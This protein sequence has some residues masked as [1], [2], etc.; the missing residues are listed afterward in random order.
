MLTGIK[1][2][3]SDR[4]F[5]TNTIIGSTT[6]I[7]PKN[8]IAAIFSRVAGLS[9]DNNGQR[10][11]PCNSTDLVP[12]TFTMGSHDFILNPQEYLF[13]FSVAGG[14]SIIIFH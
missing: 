6:M 2:D 5:D 14:V 1:S 7:L 9:F 13:P 3:R 11:I 4:L 8:V 10:L 12:F